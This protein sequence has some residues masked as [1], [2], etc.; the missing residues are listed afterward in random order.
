MSVKRTVLDCLT[1]KR[2]IDLAY[3]FDADFGPTSLN[4]DELVDELARLRRTKLEELL[5]ELSRDELKTACGWLD[6][7]TGGRE[8][9][10]IID[11]ILGLGD[12]N[13]A[14]TGKAPKPPPR[15]RA[16]LPASEEPTLFD[17]DSESGVATAAENDNGPLTLLTDGQDMD[18]VLSKLLGEVS[19]AIAA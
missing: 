13:A 4:K 7:D 5:P 8:K 18:Q 12:G 16:K 11:R 19:E 14:A 6:L 9:Q 17:E 15:R 2:L 1:R 10:I 3:A